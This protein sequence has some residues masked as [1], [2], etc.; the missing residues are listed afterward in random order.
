[1]LRDFDP[2]GN[3]RLTTS[4]ARSFAP[5]ALSSGGV[6]GKSVG[7][8]A[9]VAGLASA[10]R[11]PT[12]ETGTGAGVRGRVGAAGASVWVSVEPSRSATLASRACRR[13]YSRISASRNPSTRLSSS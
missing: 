8:V 10:R 5:A 9:T 12:V 11:P 3:V 2:A 6:P 13:L 7:C 4:N 1:M